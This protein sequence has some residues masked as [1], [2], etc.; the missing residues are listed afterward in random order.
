VNDFNTAYKAAYVH[1]QS[2]FFSPGEIGALP[3]D[4]QHIVAYRKTGQ[5]WM[6]S[7]PKRITARGFDGIN[8][9]VRGHWI[10]ARYSTLES[11]V[12]AIGPAVLERVTPELRATESDIR[13]RIRQRTEPP[14]E[15][16]A[17]SMRRQRVAEDLLVYREI[18]RVG[19]G[20]D[21]M[22]AQPRSTE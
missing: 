16:S 12:G 6:C 17:T 18:A 4:K 5:A 19:L 10:E 1:R 3:D 11:A 15:P 14:I 20:L 7:D 9:R 22:I 13:G 2:V 21:V 8:E